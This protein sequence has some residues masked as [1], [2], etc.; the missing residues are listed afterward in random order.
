MCKRQYLHQ[1]RNN[2]VNS[3]QHYIN[4]VYEQGDI[5]KQARHRSEGSDMNNKGMHRFL[6]LLI[7]SAKTTTKKKT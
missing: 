4:H 7:G 1:R 3:F 6:I 5:C 2:F